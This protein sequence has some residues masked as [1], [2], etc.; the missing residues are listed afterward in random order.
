LEESQFT[1]IPIFSI[2]FR[3]FGEIYATLG[4]AIGVGG[5]FLIWFSGYDARSFF[6]LFYLTK[7]TFLDGLL[8]FVSIFIFSFI[9]IIVFYFLAESIIVLVDIA[10]NIRKLTTTEKNFKEV[11]TFKSITNCPQ[12]GAKIAPEDIFCLNCGYKLT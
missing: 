5:C 12:C 7:N 8:F 9:V 10:K 4:A 2:L 1:I 6:P 11:K 3:C